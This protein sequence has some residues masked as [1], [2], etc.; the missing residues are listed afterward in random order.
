ML[1]KG[2]TAII[3]GAAG[4][5]GSAIA[6]EFATEGARVHVTGR[7]LAK[8]NALASAIS[9]SGGQAYATEVDALNERAVEA[10]FEDVV[11]SAGDVHVSFNAI[12][13]P[14]E[15]IQG[16]PLTHLSV[17]AFMTPATTY[18]RSHFITART[19]ARRMTQQ[20]FGTILMHTPEPAR[21]GLPGVGGM[22]PAWAALEAL[23]RSLS[24]ELASG[25]VRAV[26]LRTSGMPET[27]TIDVVFGIHAKTLGIT[28]NEF[29]ALAEA[30][31]H[32]KRSTRL[33]ELARAAVFVA[34]DRASGM[35]G[36]VMN[37][38]GGLIVD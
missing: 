2:K 5:V 34:S 9:Q 17:D 28:R 3:Y 27:S 4:N 29:R 24:A 36:T 23:N 30:P 14:Q 22:G 15:G 35:T 31:S 19:A 37:L 7:N 13:I 18:L 20:G 6:R 25:G 21:L 26:C 12:G 16:A 32:T 33:S 8:V 10:H 38:T 1:L 11:R